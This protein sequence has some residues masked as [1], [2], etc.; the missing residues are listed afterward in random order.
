MR[1]RSGRWKAWAALFCACAAV[2]FTLFSGVAFAADDLIISTPLTAGTFSGT[3][4]G[5]S[6]TLDA[7]AADG[8]TVFSGFS[9]TDTRGT[10][11]GWY[12]T[13]S[14]TRF[15]NVTVPGRH[16]TFD[17]LTMPRFAVTASEETTSAVPGTLHAAATVD[18]G[19]AG[20]VVATCDAHG[21]GMGTY[22]FTAANRVPW[23]LAITADEYAGVYHSTVTT[24][25]ATLAL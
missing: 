7:N 12:V 25:V 11:A 5:E 15:E 6:L 19:G 9:I 23:K 3:L 2:A 4:N 1:S 24:T 17:S 20:V 8:G 21:Q 18:T 16:I 10:G 22:D 14:A 13:I